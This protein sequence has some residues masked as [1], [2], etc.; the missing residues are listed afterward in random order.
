MRRFHALS[1]AAAVTAGLSSFGSMGVAAAQPAPPT[2]PAARGTVP[3][4]TASPS[5]SV[6]TTTE[7]TADAASTTYVERQTKAG[8]DIRFEDDPLSA[9]A[10]NPVGAQISAW[11]PPRRFD[12]MA[13]R[14]SFVPQLL[15]SV[16]N[17]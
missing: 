8:Q 10:G 14:R 5:S 7:A 11:H 2:E 12:L 16:E 3:A 15:V 6:R 9:L 13:P 4:V 1:V 17:L